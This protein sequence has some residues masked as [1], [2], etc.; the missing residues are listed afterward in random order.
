MDPNHSMYGQEITEETALIYCAPP[1]YNQ[2]YPIY[3][4]LAPI[5]DWGYEGLSSGKNNRTYIFTDYYYCRLAETYL[6]RAEARLRKGDAEGAAADINEVRGRA[7][8]PLITAGEVTIDY[9]LDERI[10]ELYAEERR[11]NTLL[12]IGG[13]IPNNRIQHASAIAD[14][15]GPN[16]STPL[17]TG[18]IARDFLF[19]IPQSVIDSNLD[20]NIEQNPG[21]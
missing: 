1:N 12:R 10:R 9:I 16:P 8:A 3:T 4:K 21:W 20:A 7:K 18:T 5:D 17:W 15:G 13:D 11:W 2:F 14:F 19:P 6:L